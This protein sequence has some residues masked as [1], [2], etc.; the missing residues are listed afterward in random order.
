MRATRLILAMGFIGLA[1]VS[2][3][4]WW[5]DPVMVRLRQ[6]M[7]SARIPSTTT[8]R[9]VTPRY[10]GAVF[11]AFKQLH[12]VVDQHYV[13]PDRLEAEALFEESFL[14]LKTFVEGLDW[15]HV[16]DPEV[17][18][19]PPSSIRTVTPGSYLF[20]IPGQSLIYRAVET[21]NVF[22]EGELAA[23]LLQWLEDLKIKPAGEIFG[24]FTNE[25][26]HGL[27]PHSS[28]LNEKEYA[29]LKGGTRGQFGGVGVV[30]ND[31]HGMPFVRE[32]V[33]N[34]PAHL[35]GVEPNDILIRVG[36]TRVNFNSIDD[37]LAT[38]RSE[39][40]G[41]PLPVWLFRPRSRR[42]LKTLFSREEI[43]THSVEKRHIPSHPNILHL[44]V[45]GFSSRTSQEIYDAY[46]K[47][48]SESQGAL[49]ALILDLRGNPGGLLD[50]AVQ[51]SD[52]FLS[53]GKIVVTKS[54]Y[55]TQN[56]NATESRLVNL[57]VVVLINSSSASAS[58][59]VAGAL[60]D[61]G[62][63][64]VIGERSFGKGS[65]QSLF[66]LP[67][68]G[69]LKLTI[70]HY[71]TPVGMSIQNTGI[72][73]HIEVR[74]AQL[75]EGEMWIAGS[76]EHRREEDLLH[77]LD[78]PI[79]GGA[80]SP[81]RFFEGDPKSWFWALNS[82]DLSRM[83]ALG[84]LSFSY[85]SNENSDQL[86]RRE[87]DPYIRVAL[88]TLDR[89]ADSPD[90]FWKISTR[91]QE[92]LSEVREDENLRIASALE[93]KGNGPA[94][95]FFSESES[96]L[97]QVPLPEV[98]LTWSSSGELV[99]ASK[100]LAQLRRVLPDGFLLGF[101]LT[102]ETEKPSVWQFVKTNALRERGN[103]WRI[104]S[105]R[106]FWS[107]WTS[108]QT[109]SRQVEV[110]I[111]T[112][113]SAAGRLLGRVDVS[114]LDWPRAKPLE[115]VKVTVVEHTGR[116]D[117]AERRFRVVAEYQVPDGSAGGCEVIVAGFTDRNIT[118][119][120]LHSSG[121]S[122]DRCRTAALEVSYKR[123]SLPQ[124]KPFDGVIGLLLRN[125]LGSIVGRTSL[126]E[127]V[128]GR[129]RASAEVP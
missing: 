124:A 128:G 22:Q 77:H 75:K 55:D 102:G 110:F 4:L 61:S 64:L 109:P 26:L 121:V 1:A 103:V 115:Q 80:V 68:F 117:S 67:G 15:K 99:V 59:I 40:Q 37:V 20:S 104:P 81:A 74:L 112:H 47:A 36:D 39:T 79:G 53:R 30:I 123:G 105:P 101:V 83:N 57:P 8:T 7:K 31:F 3:L 90:S 96:Q 98:Q 43:P 120:P 35:A 48:L 62:R 91:F 70:A 122:A 118:I 106:L 119:R 69:A 87:E 10:D 76:S 5:T 72:S 113:S 116:A 21:E 46:I 33:P 65:V 100:D 45:T 73:P 12:R 23:A 9:Y 44:K 32:I 34:S 71:F 6:G 14:K 24:M 49:R 17:G 56:E 25:Y 78:N 2:V 54:R 97:V 107:L 85:P 18:T 111:K 38:I 41:G 125:R 42:V 84:P 94:A 88:S 108:T 11:R 13:V 58:E 127:I 51:V 86:S 129:L 92:V 95:R 16:P 19:P 52:L 60:K 63:A 28:F 50:Q 126:A 82:D 29:E 93:E 114:G 89:L 66:E 27:D